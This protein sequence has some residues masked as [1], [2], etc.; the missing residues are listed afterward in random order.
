MAWV[1]LDDSFFINPKI[2]SAG[3]H[4]QLLYLAGLCWAAMQ[5]NDGTFP[6]SDVPAIAALAGVPQDIADTLIAAGLWHAAE[7]DCP[8][9]RSV[10]Q[11]TP[12]PSGH[13]AIHGYLEF[14]KSR[15]Q[16]TAEREAAAER[17]RRSREKSRRDSQETYAAT[18]AAPSPS[19]PVG[20][21]SSRRPTDSRGDPQP[22]ENP[23]D[24]ETGSSVPDEVWEHYADLRLAQQTNVRNPGPWKA[25]CRRNARLELAEQAARWWAT[26]EITPYRLAQALVDGQAPRNVPRR[27]AA[28]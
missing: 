9:C 2:R 19:R 17:Q 23:D 15:E 7:A 26:F 12:V 24:D 3:H 4:G 22:V 27:S 8:L 14:N 13:V 28:A 16:I 18:S 6:A 1:K 25:T 20:D 21:L 10:G 5:L 11:H